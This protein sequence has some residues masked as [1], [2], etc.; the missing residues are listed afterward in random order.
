MTDFLVRKDDLRTCRIEASDE[1]PSIEPGEAL[2][3]VDTFGLTANN[4]TYAVMGEA[5][6]YWNFFPAADGWGRVPAGNIGGV[7][8]LR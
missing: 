1:T 4:V 6:S 2:L 8:A 5:M 3:R 7:P